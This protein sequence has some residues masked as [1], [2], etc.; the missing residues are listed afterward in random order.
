MRRGWDLS[1]KN[2]TH[3]ENIQKQR[4]KL[5]TLWQQLQDEV[6]NRKN[7]LQAAALIKQVSR[8]C[9]DVWNWG[10]QV[11]F[12][13]VPCPCMLFQQKEAFRCQSSKRDLDGSL[14]ALLQACH[15][16]DLSGLCLAENC[17]W[18]LLSIK[19][20]WKYFT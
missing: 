11:W 2:P 1:Q 12:G 13:S 4:D 14:L 17:C 7:R 10:T 18:G 19:N 15:A 9:C 3:E 16:G 6:A 8:S 5:Q 20:L